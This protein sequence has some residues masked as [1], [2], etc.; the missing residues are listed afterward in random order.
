MYVLAA[1]SRDPKTK[2][3]HLRREGI[4]PGCVYGGKLEETLLNQVTNGEAAKLMREKAIGTQVLIE[5]DGEKQ[6]A[7]I[8]EISANLLNN[9][10]DHLSFQSLV[11][12]E[13]VNAV[14]QITL[15]NEDTVPDVVRQVLFELD[16]RALPAHLVEEIRIDVE[17][18]EAGMSM[19][20]EDLDIAKSPDVEI[21]TQGDVMVFNIIDEAMLAVD[22]EVEEEDLI[23]G[24]EGEEVAGEAEGEEE[25]EDTE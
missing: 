17:G 1:D 11:A 25:E 16:I 18:M 20:V 14:A 7:L 22:E 13:P 24:E 4:V 6:S 2:V 19:R 9:S 3:K 12:D 21:L 5:M 15:V 23:E 10:I 8:K